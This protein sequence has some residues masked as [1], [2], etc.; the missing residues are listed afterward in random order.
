M[1]ILMIVIIMG[2]LWGCVGMVMFIWC[3]SVCLWWW[4]LFDCVCV[5]LGEIDGV[6]GMGC[7][8]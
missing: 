1:L 7:V 2:C 6:L 3:C 8:E 5:G 4:K